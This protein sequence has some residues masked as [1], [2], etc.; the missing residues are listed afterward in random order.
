MITLDS[1]E[2]KQYKEGLERIKN[3]CLMDDEFMTKCF[4]SDTAS[5]ELVLHIVLDMP[6]LTVEEVHTQVF[7]G[8]LLH[9]SVTLDIVARDGSGRRFNVEIQ[10]TD[11]GAGGKRA[12]FHS[13]MLDA[14]LLEKSADFDSLPE[15]YVIF[16]TERDTLKGGAPLYRFDRCNIETGEPLGDGTHIIYVNGAYRGDTPLGR[17]MH[18]FSCKNADDMHY[19][20]LADRVRF[21]KESKEGVAA[22]SRVMEEICLKEREEGRIE[23]REENMRTVAQRMIAL[24]KYALEEISALSGLS[25]EEVRKLQT[26]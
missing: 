6:T 25:L 17:L 21:F 3:F 5:I 19:A 14:Q 12:R 2:E 10:R 8:N 15:T 11:K 23:G 1:I 7:V 22:M 24:G 13:S 26:Q 4:E 16:I 9:H 20:V 18:D